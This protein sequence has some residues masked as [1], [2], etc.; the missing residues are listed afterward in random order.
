MQ[1]NKANSDPLIQSCVVFDGADAVLTGRALTQI[2]DRLTTAQLK[3]TK[4][5]PLESGEIF[6]IARPNFAGAALDWLNWQQRQRHIE[7]YGINSTVKKR[8]VPKFT[9]DNFIERFT[10]R[11]MDT[12]QDNKIMRMLL[13][14]EHKVQPFDSY[15]LLFVKL[16]GS[17]QRQDAST[18]AMALQIF[19]DNVRTAYA[20]RLEFIT[21]IQQLVNHHITDLELKQDAEHLRI[22]REL[23][24]LT[25]KRQR[26]QDNEDTKRPRF[27]LSDK[28]YCVKHGE[29]NHDSRDC[30]HLQKLV[31]NDKSGSYSTDKAKKA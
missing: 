22:T 5:S 18:E 2:V 23:L 15:R 14:L 3:A 20:P 6:K 31:D 25:L 11:F 12:L 21:S 8:G 16:F 26:E 27:G 4:E 9:P 29:G 30:R 1:L 24:L 28:F 7:E 10:E 17:L 19:K 13:N